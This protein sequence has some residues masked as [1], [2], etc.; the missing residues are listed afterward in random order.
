MRLSDV[1]GR[2]EENDNAKAWSLLVTMTKA[3]KM[4][5]TMSGMM[6]R[7]GNVREFI[8]TTRQFTKEIKVK[9]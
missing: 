8:T 7:F 3:C 4:S 6:M 1:N 2:M 5:S 9:K